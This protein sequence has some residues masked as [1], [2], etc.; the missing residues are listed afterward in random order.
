MV[1]LP[2][3]SGKATALTIFVRKCKLVPVGS[4][5]CRFTFELAVDVGS[6][7]AITIRFMKHCR[8]LQ[9]NDFFQAHELIE[10]IKTVLQILSKMTTI[11]LIFIPVQAGSH[12]VAN[13][14]R[15]AIASRIFVDK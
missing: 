11:D 15:P 1:Y 8:T 13:L 10:F 9:G 3:V 7:L 12:Y 5:H 4:V 2:V 6:F 14:L